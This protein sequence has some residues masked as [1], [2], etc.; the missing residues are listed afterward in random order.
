MFGIKNADVEEIKMV[1][2]IRER[3]KSLDWALIQNELDE[4]GYHY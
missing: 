4:Q 1:Q 2:D 3:V